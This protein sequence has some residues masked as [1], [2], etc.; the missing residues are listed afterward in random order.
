MGE[1]PNELHVALQQVLE[2]RNGEET[3]LELTARLFPE[4][5]LESG[6]LRVNLVVL[7]LPLRR[8]YASGP[9]GTGRRAEWHWPLK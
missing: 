1:P 8:V 6:E 5:L 3:G 2:R 9:R 7:G 4:P